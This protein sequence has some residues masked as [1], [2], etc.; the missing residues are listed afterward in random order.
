MRKIKQ[1]VITLFLLTSLPYVT[2]AQ[3]FEVVRGDCTPDLSDGASTTRGVRRLLPTPSKMWDANR[4]YKQMV[5]LVEF[6][7]VSFN[8]EDPRATYDTM[9]NE[10]G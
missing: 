10:P 3:G 5:I 1:I 7:D 6:S 8:R 9:F 2:L 4:I